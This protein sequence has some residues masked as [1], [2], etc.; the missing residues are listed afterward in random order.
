M[1]NYKKIVRPCVSFVLVTAMA[2]PLAACH[3]TDN[4]NGPVD[5]PSPP[6]TISIG[7]TET[8]VLALGDAPIQLTV[9][10]ENSDS[11]E[12]VWESSNPRYLKV[13]SDGL[14]SVIEE[15]IGRAHV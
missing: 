12:V 3:R 11:S 13:T 10:V 4:P 5:P 8:T 2:L 14:V 7:E 9:S 6:P 1:K 15:Q